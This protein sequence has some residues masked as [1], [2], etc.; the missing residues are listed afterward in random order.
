MKECEKENKYL[1]LAWELKKLWNMKVTIILIA[2]CAFGTVTKELSKDWRTW[3]LEDEWRPSKQQHYWEWLEYWE[4]SRRLETCCHS[5]SSEK[6]SV[7]T[8]V[9]NSQWVN[10]KL[11]SWFTIKLNQLTKQINHYYGVVI[12]VLI[13]GGGVFVV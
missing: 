11:K 1:D 2:I 10:N 5:N 8:D 3:K 13:R 7:K 9:K 12:L 6:P 4:K